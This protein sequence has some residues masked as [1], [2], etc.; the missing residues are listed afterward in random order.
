M[1]K[2]IGIDLGTANTLIY[3]KGKGI[4]VNEPSV[5]AVNTRTGRVLAV[6]Q[7]AKDMIG[8]TAEEVAVIKPL[9]NGVIADFDVTRAML[10]GFIDMAGIR[11]VLR[12]YVTVCAP[13]GI[14]E[15]ERRAILEAIVH[16]GGKN[17]FLIEEPMAAA[18]GASLPVD[19]PYGSMVVD[20]G[21]GTTEVA[22]VSFGGIVSST[23]VLY[24]GN[25]MDSDIV[26]YI[27]SAY[28]LLIGER[29]A[30][31]IKINIGVANPDQPE[32]NMKVLG[33]D[34]VTGLPKVITVSSFEVYEAIKQTV[35]KIVDAV[36]TTL[37]N[38][39]PE[40]ASDIASAG[41]VICGGG[42]NLPG[43]DALI[44]DATGISAFVTEEPEN[45]VAKGAGMAIV[46]ALE[47]AKNERIIKKAFFHRA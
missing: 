35:G 18:L 43:L 15:V 12:P 8:K 42:A 27:K 47:N 45:C 7:K 40:L 28:N 33:R 39:P 20:I 36:K 10:K 4:V 37:E 14:T 25:K 38:T 29:T 1:A 31:A 44:K 32:K 46:S 30:E 23:S 19:E 21:G 2:Y 41:I 22:V 24:A 9:K 6:G 11:G 5:V 16:S 13:F 34:L 3:L 26:S 17:T